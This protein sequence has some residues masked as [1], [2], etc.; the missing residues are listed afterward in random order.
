MHSFGAQLVLCPQGAVARGRGG[1]RFVSDAAPDLWPSRDGSSSSIS[2]GTAAKRPGSGARQ[3]VDARPA[4]G[5]GVFRPLAADGSAAVSDGGVDTPSS[6]AAAQAA[7]RQRVTFAAQPPGAVPRPSIMQ[8]M[9]GTTAACDDA[10]Q[11]AGRAEQD[12]QQQQQKQ[13]QQKQRA[14]PQPS[15]SGAPGEGGAAQP[16]KPAQQWDQCSD[17][18]QVWQHPLGAATSW[19]GGGGLLPPL[20]DVGLPALQFGNVQAPLA[21]AAGVPAQP[22]VAAAARSSAPLGIG[23]AAAAPAVVT[24]PAAQIKAQPTAAAD[25]S[26]Q[27]GNAADMSSMLHTVA[28]VPSI[29]GTAPATGKDSATGQPA[30]AAG[31]A[32][33]SSVAAAAAGVTGGVSPAQQTP[34]LSALDTI[35]S[36]LPSAQ[37]PALPAASPALPQPAVMPAASPLLPDVAQPQL[38]QSGAA[39]PQPPSAAPAV[40]PAIK[41][42]SAAPT[43][44]AAPPQLAR[45]Q[46]P[47]PET[48]TPT[49]P[50][51]SAQQSA[52]QP[53]GK[54]LAPE[55]PAKAQ[56]S[57]QPQILNPKPVE[58]TASAAAV[59][60][61]TKPAESKPA[62]QPAKASDA[63]SAEQAAPPAAAKAP[64]G[65]LTQPPQAKPAPAAPKP[66]AAPAP[67]L[68]Q[69]KPPPSAPKP[70]LPQQQPRVKQALPPA[71]K[72]PASKPLSGTRPPAPAPAAK[73]IEPMP[74]AAA[75]AADVAKQLRQGL[76]AAQGEAYDKIAARVRGLGS[77]LAPAVAP[78][79]L[80]TPSASS[81]STDGSGKAGPATAPAPAD[82]PPLRLQME[83]KSDP[84][85]P[86]SLMGSHPLVGTD[87]GDA[88]GGKRGGKPAPSAGKTAGAAKRGTVAAGAAI[89]GGASGEDDEDERPP[90][91]SKAEAAGRVLQMIADTLLT[92]YRRLG[93]TIV[94]YDYAGAAS[95]VAVTLFQAVRDADY[96]EAGRATGAA[97]SAALQRA[98]DA[99]TRAGEAAQNL[100][101]EELRTGVR[102]AFAAAGRQLSDGWGYVKTE[103]LALERGLEE[104]DGQK[105]I[106]SAEAWAEAE[107]DP[108]QNPALAKAEADLGAVI[109]SALVDKPYE[110]IVRPLAEG[111]KSV[112][113]GLA[114]R[115]GGGYSAGLSG[116]RRGLGTAL[117]VLRLTGIAPVGGSEG[118]G[119][120]EEDVRQT[121]EAPGLSG[122]SGGGGGGGGDSG[123]GAAPAAAS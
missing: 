24:Q 45:S 58:K 27:D 62:Q 23:A 117:R 16:T 8:M 66:Q 19:V 32:A 73:P 81:P 123:S 3:L 67:Q 78:T 72:P 29:E 57:N 12:R 87:G 40:K 30:S 49:A 46:A 75:A 50:V 92:G 118:S 91:P 109:K 11:S 38:Q 48:A 55:A 22:A 70:Q 79:A 25:S 31:E 98:S 101:P 5:S 84:P 71:N 88:K 26:L 1:M 86:K 43:A 110:E 18:C 51:S 68:Q 122:S 100:Q 105:A 47:P 99:A 20:A 9:P 7:W 56:Q 114:Q 106:E 60:S 15:G 54:A 120:L 28:K 115:L 52:P 10:S 94:S 90:P 96:A 108:A 121:L 112:A 39:A 97:L 21:A 85:V 64:T 36:L 14:A 69:A 17:R 13:Q 63:K 41:A 44:A 89:S 113:E 83:L 4:P 104:F 119:G 33:G 35:K 95:G 77:S 6:L 93:V 82:P 111:G 59:S 76:K 34:Q 65:S 116:L 2:R 80:G 102:D 74:P 103:V 107:L 53:A 37:P 61:Q 42:A